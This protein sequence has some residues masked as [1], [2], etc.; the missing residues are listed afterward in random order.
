MDH[1]K[2][3]RCAPI[4]AILALFA[5]SAFGSSDST[6]LK[7]ILLGNGSFEFGQIVNG[8]YSKTPDGSGLLNHY[9]LE[10]GVLQLGGEIKSDNGLNILLLGQ[11]VLSFPY[12]LPTDGS[13]AGGFASYSPKYTWTVWQADADYSFGDIENPFLNI[14]AGYFPFKYNPDA[15]NFGDYLFRINPYPQYLQTNFDMPYTQL[16]GLRVGSTPVS[17]LRI[18][19]LLTSESLLWPLRDFSLAALAS[20]KLMNFV[21]V[22]AGVMWDRLL[23]V[24]DKITN[25]P[26]SVNSGNYSFQGTKVE[27]R[28]A[29]DLKQLF[30]GFDVFGKNDLRLYGELCLNGL[31]DYPIIDTTNP[32]YP[33]YNSLS[34]RE[35]ILLGFNI[36]TFKFMEVLSVEAE[37]WDNNYANSYYNVLN[38]GYALVPNPTKIGAEHIAQSYGGAWHWSV[39]AKKNITQ[40]LNLIG[41]VSR[42][43]TF[44]ETSMTGTSNADPEEALDGLGDWMWRLKLEYCF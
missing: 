34:K 8:Q 5:I 27:F 25:P 10:K 13:G 11:G 14:T 1:G 35:P 42:D 20:Y 2:K 36:P 19:A 32:L 24:D 43:H 17:N 4:I 26:V 37:W 41:Q 40:N 21:E 18:D 33:G 7:A 30:P 12:C 29:L 16:L 15:R 22:G 23:S 6:R 39:Y 9:A 31:K 28:G 44:I 3:H 38:A